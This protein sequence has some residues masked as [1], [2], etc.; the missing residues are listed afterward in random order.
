MGFPGRRS[1]LYRRVPVWS[2]P[3][4]RSGSRLP[5]PPQYASGLKRGIPGTS[6][7]GLQ[8]SIEGARPRR[9]DRTRIRELR[10]AIGEIGDSSGVEERSIGR[11]AVIENIVRTGVDLERLVNLIRGVQVENRIGS[12]PLCLIGFIADKIL[13]AD[14]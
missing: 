1:R 12:Q 9:T 10:A 13:A 2:D 11:I 3:G 8:A 5:G 14:E 4:L 7:G 6:E